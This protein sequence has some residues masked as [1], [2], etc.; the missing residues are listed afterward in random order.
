[1]E[2]NKQL[3][4]EVKEMLAGMSQMES[5]MKLWIIIILETKQTN[6]EELKEVM[7]T[8][9]LQQAVSAISSTR[10][11]EKKEKVI[12]DEPVQIIVVNEDKQEK[13]KVNSILISLSAIA[14]YAMLHLLF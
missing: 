5:G 12:S 7:Q 6:L 1:M 4:L 8:N 14:T 3:L 11:V 13:L 9:A 10:P 2:D